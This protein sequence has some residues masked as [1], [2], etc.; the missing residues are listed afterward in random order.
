MQSGVAHSEVTAAVVAAND[1]T[2]AAGM[3][4]LLATVL[5]LTE[6]TLPPIP[7]RAS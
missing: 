5:E 1:T 2:G 6:L 3:V 7:S 4:S